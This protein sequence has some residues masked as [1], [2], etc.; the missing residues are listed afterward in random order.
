MQYHPDGT[1]ILNFS[2]IGQTIQ[3]RKNNKEYTLVYSSRK[4]MFKYGNLYKHIAKAKK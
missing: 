3:D 2:E 4:E 1:P